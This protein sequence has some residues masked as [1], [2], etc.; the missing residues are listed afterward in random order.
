MTFLQ[1]S[2]STRTLNCFLK[3]A[4]R[5]RIVSNERVYGVLAGWNEIKDKLRI[6]LFA[7]FFRFH[8]AIVPSGLTFSGV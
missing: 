7:S 1:R 6:R 4:R 8:L 3:T 2:R 5:R